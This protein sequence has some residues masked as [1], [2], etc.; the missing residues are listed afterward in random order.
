M[1]PEA[2]GLAVTLLTAALPLRAQ[3]AGGAPGPVAAARAAI[4][5]TAR[6]RFAAAGRTVGL[7]P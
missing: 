1:I 7:P 5:R 2:A 6:A 3:G 4:T